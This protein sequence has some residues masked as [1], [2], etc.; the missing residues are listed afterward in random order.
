MAGITQEQLE[1][2]LSYARIDEDDQELV[3]SLMELAI[4]YL[5]GAGIPEPETWGKRYAFA[6]NALTLHYYD[7]RDDQDAQTAHPPAL[8]VLINQLKLDALTEAAAAPAG[9]PEP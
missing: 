3:T 9:E 7:H 2:C 8:R 4:E 1:S 6:V 5:A